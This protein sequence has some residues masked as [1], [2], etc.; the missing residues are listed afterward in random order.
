MYKPR[1]NNWFPDMQLN[2]L[3]G[4]NDRGRLIHFRDCFLM[5]MQFVRPAAVLARWALM[6]FQRILVMIDLCPCWWSVDSW[7]WWFV[8]VHD[9]FQPTSDGDEETSAPITL[10]K[11]SPRPVIV[12]GISWCQDPELPL[13]GACSIRITRVGRTH[14]RLCILDC[15]MKMLACQA[16]WQK[17]RHTIALYSWDR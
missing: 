7:R 5:T 6:V 3:R 14:L 4:C 2:V 8:L 9:D 1:S 12:G 15:Q 17:I 10:K 16:C 11:L 13:Q